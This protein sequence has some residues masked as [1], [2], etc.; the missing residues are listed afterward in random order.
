[1]SSFNVEELL[2]TI[3]R[4][5]AAEQRVARERVSAAVALPA[6]A[7][8]AALGMLAVDI[9]ST[10]TQPLHRHTRRSPARAVATVRSA[11]RV[12]MPTRRVAQ[13]A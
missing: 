4:L 1:M 9:A 2:A 12:S 5:D 13:P 6:P 10:Q 7:A 8:R 3:E 11:A